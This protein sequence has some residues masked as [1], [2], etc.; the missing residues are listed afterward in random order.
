ME[1]IVLQEVR[2]RGELA[3]LVRT[4]WRVLPLQASK[5]SYFLQN[6]YLYLFS[7]ATTTSTTT[8]LLSLLAIN[9]ERRPVNHFSDRKA[10]VAI[11]EEL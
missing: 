3:G 5:Y 10:T 8:R 4:R 1:Q 2:V 11:L 9:C 6:Y 7:T